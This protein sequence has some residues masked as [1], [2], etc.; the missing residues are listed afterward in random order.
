MCVRMYEV[1]LTSIR[2]LGYWRVVN[3]QISLGLWTHVCQLYVL[4]FL[5]A[6]LKIRERV[7]AKA[8]K[9]RVSERA[10]ASM[11]YIGF[12]ITWPAP[13]ERLIFCAGQVLL[14]FQTCGR[15]W[16]HWHM[17]ILS[18]QVLKRLNLFWCPTIF[19]S[20]TSFLHVSFGSYFSKIFRSSCSSLPGL[21]IWECKS[22]T[23]TV[24]VV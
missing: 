8:V 19:V 10:S 1:M 14:G 13:N 24:L 15:S 7:R 22:Y 21:K 18:N 20:G 16:R 2:S 6:Y 12:L 3:I 4:S 17:T 5:A 11:K 23:I 9:L